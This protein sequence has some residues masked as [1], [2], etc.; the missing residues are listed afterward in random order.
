MRSTTR[1]AAPLT[2]GLAVA[3]A[4]GLALGLA[5]CSDD[6]PAEDPGHGPG[7]AAVEPATLP[8]DLCAAVPA[9]LTEKWRLT[10]RAHD[11]T[12]ETT[13]A[14]AT[15]AMTGSYLG[16]P[17]T[18]DLRMT[19][20][21]GE[22]RDAARKAMADGVATACAGLRTD[23]PAFTETDH[24]CRLRDP[25]RTTEVARSVPTYGVVRVEATFGGDNEAGVAA[26]V[27][28][29]T[30]ILSTTDPADLG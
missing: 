14:T 29:L 8:T 10:P 26:E 25:G 30:G 24:A 9:D 6:D 16:E 28:R 3:L 27:A 1:G 11:A 2:A 17:L 5:A 20:L 13:S 22:S 19:A 7:A 4:S 12:R 15:C 21:A 18:L 23:P